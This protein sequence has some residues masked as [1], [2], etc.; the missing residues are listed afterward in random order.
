[1]NWSDIAGT[2]GKAAPMLGTLVG[3]PA[4]A[5]VGAIAAIA[6]V[7]VSG[8][9]PDLTREAPQP[10]MD[11]DLMPVGKISVATHRPDHRE[12]GG[13]RERN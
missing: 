6:L 11:V 8:E 3:G 12:G 5:A 9:L 1:M 4:G 13:R 7:M 2:I 10:L